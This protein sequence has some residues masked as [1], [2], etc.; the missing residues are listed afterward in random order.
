MSKKEKGRS[1]GGAGPEGGIPEAEI[2]MMPKPTQQEL[3]NPDVLE[4]RRKIHSSLTAKLS[5]TRLI[6][7]P[8][9]GAQIPENKA[10]GD[11]SSTIY[12]DCRYIGPPPKSEQ[13]QTDRGY[14][15]DIGFLPR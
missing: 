13:R 1:E 14:S 6:K 4:M 9:C 15:G 3:A 10:M 12:C 2:P 11:S 8:R 5:N 7:C